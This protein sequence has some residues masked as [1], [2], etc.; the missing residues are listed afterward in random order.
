MPDEDTRLRDEEFN[1]E[2][3]VENAQ[4]E[5]P[6][7]EMNEMFNQSILEGGNLVGRLSTTQ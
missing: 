3:S 1:G 4:P 5:D 7:A 6:E 2:E